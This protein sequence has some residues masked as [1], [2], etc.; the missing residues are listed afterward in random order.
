MS[1]GRPNRNQPSESSQ[2]I[3][4]E[5]AVLLGSSDDTGRLLNQ[6]LQGSEKASTRRER[7][8]WIP[9]SSGRSGAY[10]THL[11]AVHKR[12]L[13]LPPPKK[14]T[15]AACLILF[16]VVA[17]GSMLYSAIVH[18]DLSA[19]NPILLPG[20]T[21]A[22]GVYIWRSHADTVVIDAEAQTM[23]VGRDLLSMGKGAGRWASIS[24]V[25]AVQCIQKH[26]KL[27]RKDNSKREVRVLKRMELNLVRENG[28]RLHV[29]DMEG[30]DAARLAAEE[31]V[32]LLE[33][34]CLT[35]P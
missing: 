20:M 15:T 28:S 6:S 26:Q 8:A 21:A 23:W 2:F 25:W 5:Q 14:N 33:L 4:H 22:L 7:V 30:L 12:L 32:A 27:P 13:V 3:Y 29:V 35:H 17:V 31:L 9:Q 34:E 16:S 11:E 1:H 18:G 19:L 24:D 10:Q